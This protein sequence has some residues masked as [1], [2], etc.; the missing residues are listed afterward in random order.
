MPEI[1]CGHCGASHTSVAE[2]RACALDH[3]DVAERMAT[4]AR[5]AREIR[6][7]AGQR[8]RVVVDAETVDKLEALGY[9][10]D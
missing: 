5:K 1:S 7:N 6:E 9:T 4:I 8:E 2:V 3:P 10:G